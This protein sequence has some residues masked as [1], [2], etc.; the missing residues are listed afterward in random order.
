MARHRTWD[1]EAYTPYY[2]D[3]DPSLYR[4]SIWRRL[5]LIGIV[6]VP[7]V[8]AVLLIYS[9]MRAYIAPPTVSVA[10]TSL[11][12][13]EREPNMIVPMTTQPRADGTI[14]R[15][16][17]LQ[18]AQPQTNRLAIARAAPEPEPQSGGAG[19]SVIPW[20][21]TAPTARNDALPPAADITGS[22]SALEAVPLPRRRP[23]QATAADAVRALARSGSIIP[24][25]S[26][27]SPPVPLEPAAGTN[28][29][30]PH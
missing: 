8:A 28:Y 15:R 3:D 9:F 25:D 14:P 5:L 1:S 11:A 13:R 27:P 12:M 29:G 7:I 24:L 22:F 16:V 17:D 18:S 21:G 19:P 20:P 4:P 23:R 2:E 6:L 26:V 10:P 30:T